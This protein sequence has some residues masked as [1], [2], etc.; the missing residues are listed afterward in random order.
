MADKKVRKTLQRLVEICRDGQQGYTEA[1]EHISD[2]S[3][4]A[5]FHDES[6]E[7]GRYALE[8]ESELSRLG[9]AEVGAT[10]SVAGALHRGWLNLTATVAG[11]DTVLAAVEQGEDKAKQV[12]EEALKE[13]L[14]E[15][16]EGTVR[17]Q[18]QGVI[19]AHDHVK[20]LRD[21]RLSA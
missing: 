12:Y 4:R 3:L 7:R 1:A 15:T 16:V 17:S 10:G 9:D 8:L 20:L 18:A 19:A 6:L 5:F 14:P 21:K 2:S 11:D 13:P